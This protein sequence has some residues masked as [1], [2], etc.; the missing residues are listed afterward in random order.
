MKVT[1]TKPLVLENR[2]RGSHGN[3]KNGENQVHLQ[4]IKSVDEG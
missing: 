3:D 1:Q 4:K 2:N